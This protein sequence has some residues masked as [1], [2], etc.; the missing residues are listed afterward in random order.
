M[1]PDRGALLLHHAG[2]AG[3][4]DQRGYQK[5]DDREH[6]SYGPSSWSAFSPYPENSGRELVIAY[7]L[8]F[9]ISAI[10]FRIADFSRRLSILGLGF[11]LLAVSSYS[12]LVSFQFRFLWR[13]VHSRHGQRGFLRMEFLPSGIDLLPAPTLSG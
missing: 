8:G 2:H 1:V 3:K 4:A 12:F 9:S 5:E 11:G 10:S 7:H 6:L 13:S